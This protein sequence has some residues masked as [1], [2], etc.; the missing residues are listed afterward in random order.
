MYV[1]HFENKPPIYKKFTCKNKCIYTNGK[2][3]NGLMYLSQEFQINVINAFNTY[4][5]SYIIRIRFAFITCKTHAHFVVRKSL[6]IFFN[7]SM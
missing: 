2:L 7:H 3:E 5:K 6:N 1:G 4:T